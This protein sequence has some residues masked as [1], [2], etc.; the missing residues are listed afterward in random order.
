MATYK[1]IN[2]KQK[3]N[4]RCSYKCPH[5][6]TV[7]P[8][9]NRAYALGDTLVDIQCPH[10]GFEKSFFNTS[11]YFDDASCAKCGE[12]TYRGEDKKPIPKYQPAPVVTCP[13]CNS[14]NTKK[15]STMS[16]AGS[17]AL[18]GVFALGKTTKEWH[19]NN[20]KSDF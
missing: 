6:D 9:E 13:Y 10:C 15:I 12:T 16:K 18:W 19:C 1:C 17:V 8:L 2:C 20:C 4:P 11:D 3:I 5:C 14:T 7:Q